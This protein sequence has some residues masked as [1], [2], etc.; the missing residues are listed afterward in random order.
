MKFKQIALSLLL[1]FSFTACQKP[2]A[3]INTPKTNTPSQKS[4]RLTGKPVRIGVLSIDS[5]VSVN[6][7]YRPLLDYL[8]ETIGR[9]FQLV[10]VSQDSQFT[11][12]EAGNLDFTTNNPLAAVQI[13]RLYNTEFLVT[14]SR[15]KTGTLFSALIVVK[16][17]SDI[18]SVEDLQGKKVACVDFETAAAG[19]VFQIYHLQQKGINPFQDF[20]S[21][22]EN[23]S[24]DNIVLA[25]LNGTINA[26]FIRTGQLEKMVE[27][28]LINN[29]DELRIIDRASDNFPYAHTTSLYPEWPIAALKN[30]D[31]QLVKDVKEALLN[32]PP[33]H[34]ALSSAKIEGFA[35]VE[36][37]EQLERLIETLKLKSWDAHL[38]INNEQ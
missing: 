38:T 4:D 33:E 19:C 32:I 13:R 12:V 21:F 6:E 16:Q 9:P 3:N 14:H 23:K 20:S 18:K 27:K 31:P 36:D 34:P 25:V 37:Y 10:T 5:A 29:V 2:Q 22:I 7:R 1:I 28:G 15:P 24:Q 11:E 17:N 26:G 35:P 30:T 8:E